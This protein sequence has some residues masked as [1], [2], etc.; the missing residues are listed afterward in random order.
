MVKFHDCIIQHGGRD[1]E[2]KVHQAVGVL[3]MFKKPLL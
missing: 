3:Y 1:I 2:N